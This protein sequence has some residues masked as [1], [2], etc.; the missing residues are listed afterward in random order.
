MATGYFQAPDTSFYG[1]RKW[2][3]FFFL[4]RSI[5]AMG[6]SEFDA[7]WRHHQRPADATY[8]HSA[9]LPDPLPSPRPPCTTPTRLYTQRR[10]ADSSPCIVARHT[11]HRL[12][13][14]DEPRAVGGS[15]TGPT[16]LHRL[17][18]HGELAQVVAH[19]LRLKTDAPGS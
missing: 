18:R 16:V 7:R 15:D 9:R 4:S 14:R 17:V 8:L 13:E 19:H 11:G 1:K 3:A 2:I 6:G 12:L 10:G 5:S